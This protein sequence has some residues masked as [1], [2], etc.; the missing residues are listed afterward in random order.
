MIG[1]DGRDSRCTAHG[2]CGTVGPAY[3]IMVVEVDPVTHTPRGQ[4]AALYSDHVHGY[5]DGAAGS[6]FVV[7]SFP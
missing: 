2:Y 4:A 5:P 6:V 1:P 3:T 7:S